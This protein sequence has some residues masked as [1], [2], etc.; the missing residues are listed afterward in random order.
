MRFDFTAEQQALAD[1]VREFA[2]AQVAPVSQ[3]GDATGEYASGLLAALAGEGLLGLGV[4]EIYG[5]TGADAVS[6]G[7][8]LEELARADLSAC[9]PVL[10][11]ALIGGILAANGTEEQCKA[12]LPPIADGTAVAALCLTEPGHGTDAAAI[13]LAAEADGDGWR[14]TGQKASINLGRY[15]THGLVFARTGGPGARGI[16]AFYLPLDGPQVTRT[17]HHDHG[18]RA[19]GRCT[20]TFDGLPAATDTV[21]GGPGLGFIQVMRGFDYSRALIALISVGTASASL[22]AALDRAREREVFGK[23]LGSFQAAS[24]PL[25]E[26]ATLLHA[27]RLLAYEALWRKDAG[28]DHRVEANMAKWWAP[29]VSGEA[30]H[31]ALLTFGQQGW[32]DDLPLGQRL[33]DVMSTEIADGTANVTKLVV[34]RQLLGREHAP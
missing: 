14:L 26:N 24:F 1:R 4:A 20:L 11:A 12:W 28:L 25:V 31:Q 34:A 15:A 10:N 22:D 19:G 17:P 18:S 21:I 3:Q 32:S 13:E 27:A 30:A 16:T 33:R 7:I 8:A 5:G 29:K 9:W 23:P 6:T 2:A